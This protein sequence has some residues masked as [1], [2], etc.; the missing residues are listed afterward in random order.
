MKVATAFVLLA[1]LL[2]PLPLHAEAS[3]ERSWNLGDVLNLGS[4]LV[5]EAIHQGLTAIEDHVDVE[6]A[7]NDAA[8]NGKD[9]ERSARFRLHVYPKGKREPQEQVGAEGTLRYSTDPAHPHLNLDLRLTPSIP[10][11]ET[12]L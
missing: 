8:G 12:L 6:V 9:G 5:T 2:A 7:T 4:R 10:N 1:L 11:S 3:S